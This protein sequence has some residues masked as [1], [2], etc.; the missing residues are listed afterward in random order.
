MSEGPLPHTV[1]TRKAVTREA[2]YSGVLGAAELP[3]LK[4]V[5]GAADTAPVSAEMRFFRDEEER[6]VVAVKLHARVRLEC[7]RCLEMFDTDIASESELAI[8]RS[9]EEAQALPA[10]YEP[11]IA[12]EEADLWRIVEEEL[13][14]ALPVVAYHPAGECAVAPVPGEAA[15]PEESAGG[16]A[17]RERGESAGEERPNPF[18]VLSSLLE[19]KGEAEDD[20]EDDPES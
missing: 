1:I 19:Q 8:V 4:D 10:R 9:D 20:P 15:L 14:L 11:L 18:G 17:R 5:L 3:Q 16:G 2:R 7:Q 6:Q 13:A 12:L